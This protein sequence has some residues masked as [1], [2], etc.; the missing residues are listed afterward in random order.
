MACMTKLINK[1]YR[2]TQKPKPFK[3]LDDDKPDETDFEFKVDPK[4]NKRRRVQS[5]PNFN[6]DK[7]KFKNQNETLKVAKTK[8]L[9]KDLFNDGTLTKMETDKVNKKMED[10]EFLNDIYIL[11]QA[12]GGAPDHKKKIAK[13]IKDSIK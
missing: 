2:A 8:R 6:F 12:L 5:E 10:K 11:D 1:V 9:I 7:D 13:H 4:L 3:V